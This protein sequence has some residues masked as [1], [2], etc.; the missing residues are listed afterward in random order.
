MEPSIFY[1]KLFFEDVDNVKENK[2]TLLFIT[3]NLSNFLEKSSHN[4]ELELRKHTNLFVWREHSNI[5][6]ILTNLPTQPDFI[7]LNDYHPTYC[8]FIRGLDTTN[9]PIG[10]MMHDL[11]YKK[12]S[13]KRMIEKGNVSLIFTHYRDAFLKWYPEFTD[14]MVWFPHH[15][16]TDVFKDYRSSR[17]INWLMTGK[18][19][20]DLY[21]LRTEILR[22]MKGMKGF[23]YHTHPGYRNVSHNELVGER[24]AKELNRAKM[25]LTCDSI[26]HF[27]LLKYFETLA[28]NTLL[29]APA[30]NELTDL[31]FIDG[32]TFVA[33]DESN[34]IAKANEYLHDE[35]TRVSIA[36]KG[37]EMV[38]SKHSTVTRT[39]E[40]IQH[41]KDHVKKGK[42]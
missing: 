34:F 41:I 9:I 23:T 15:V 33:I 31:G 10:V 42:K 38:H 11:H 32:E 5:Q 1:R 40:L 27:P 4:L 12:S 22:Q 20:P 16:Q 39:K 8:P 24:Y 19:I 25:C 14:R 7:L 21:P 2:L 30:S 36:R 6:H 35:K 18:I 13:R 37:Y 29:L 3:K 26:H 17:N 28:C